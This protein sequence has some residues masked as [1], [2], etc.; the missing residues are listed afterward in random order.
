MDRLWHLLSAMRGPD[1]WAR[2]LFVV[3][4]AAACS[5]STPPPGPER[6]P[7]PT[8]PS[9]L[10][11]ADCSGGEQCRDGVCMRPGIERTGDDVR[12]P[13]GCGPLQFCKHGVCVGRILADAGV[14][15]IADASADDMDAD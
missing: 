2:C 9:C 4:V 12:C 6:S 14:P 3:V 1:R 13:Q 7:S 10:T 5:S 15:P 8:L 11:D